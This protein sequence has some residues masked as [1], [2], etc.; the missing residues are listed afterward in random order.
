MTLKTLAHSAHTLLQ[1]RAGLSFPRSHVYEL[2][3][4]TLGYKSWASFNSDALLADAGLTALPETA[5][6]DCFG[7]AYQLGYPSALAEAIAIDVI[8]FAKGKQLCVVRWADLQ[9]FLLMPQIA[10]H[11]ED[12]FHD[13]ENEDWL[14]ETDHRA[15][16]SQTFSQE[17]LLS[18]PLLIDSLTT[19]C[20]KESKALFALAAIHRCK[21][22]N[23]YLYEE[24][25]KGR[26]L[27]AAEQGWAD[28]YL[29][30]KPRYKLYKQ[31]LRTAAESGVRQ[32]ALEYGL[33]FEQ[34]EFIALAERLEGDVDTLQMAHASTTEQA[35][36][37]WFRKAA[38]EGSLRALEILAHQGD[39]W[40]EDRLAKYADS[41]W[42]RRFAERALENGD[43][44]RAWTWQ[45]V[46][47]RDHCDLT[48][49]TLRA[50]HSE[51][52]HAGQLYDDDVGGPMYVDGD[53]GLE[54][55]EITSEQHRKA[56][57]IA[58]TIL[59]A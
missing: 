41:Y 35:K 10:E 58:R 11:L 17:A 57:S 43:V 55:P 50:R 23:S 28:N 53:E 39:P 31:Y 13:D 6:T 22:P 37:F 27:N 18:S 3:A 47:L 56:Q 52:S 8:N 16:E 5:L 14:D 29:V 33:V 9:P 59:K 48:H 21:K 30:Q 40:A 51:G 49:S 12:E 45:Y 20:S 32:A 26:V 38:E 15:A 42:L 2:I 36:K 34:R 54:L 7:R 1:A 4:A 19:T 25:L 46:A 44:L 24:S